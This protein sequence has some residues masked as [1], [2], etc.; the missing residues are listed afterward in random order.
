MWFA[1][2]IKSRCAYGLTDRWPRGRGPGK[3]AA[4][5]D[6]QYGRGVP[7]PAL[8]QTQAARWFFRRTLVRLRSFAESAWKIFQTCA[9]D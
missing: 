4:A 6:A 7:V 1:K 5:S 9:L 2:A 3:T 8:R